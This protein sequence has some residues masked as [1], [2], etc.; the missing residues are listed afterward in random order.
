MLFCFAE[1]NRLNASFGYFSSPDRCHHHL[2]FTHK[3]IP[4][5]IWLS[6]NTNFLIVC[7]QSANC[8]Y[9]WFVSLGYLQPKASSVKARARKAS[10]WRLYIT[11]F[12]ANLLQLWIGVKKIILLLNLLLNFVSIGS[13]V[14]ANFWAGRPCL[15]PH[16]QTVME[17]ME[18]P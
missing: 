13:T 14:E 10:P 8:W 11:E 1:K 18:W 3:Q 6:S 5:V 2:S 12:G 16:Q 15:S 17:W 9:C 4:R 7:F